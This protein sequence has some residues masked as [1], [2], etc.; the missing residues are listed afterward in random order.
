MADCRRHVQPS[1]GYYKLLS[2]GEITPKGFQEVK[3]AQHLD[4][5]MAF[6]FFKAQLVLSR[7]VTT[8]HSRT[9]EEEPEQLPEG[10]FYVEKLLSR[11]RNANAYKSVII[12][13][14]I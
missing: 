4:F 5:S 11:R 3:L 2:E 7:S 10:Q 9:H 6:L 13:I 12:T 8:G 14:I 1:K